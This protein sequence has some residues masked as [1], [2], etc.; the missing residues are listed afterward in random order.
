MEIVKPPKLFMFLLLPAFVP[1]R[2]L[3]RCRN[4]APRPKPSQAETKLG[5]SNDATEALHDPTRKKCHVRLAAAKAGLEVFAPHLLIRGRAVTMENGSQ[6]KAR[7]VG[8]TVL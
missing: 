2:G 3:S 4:A 7:C 1:P 6:T 8:E 5:Q